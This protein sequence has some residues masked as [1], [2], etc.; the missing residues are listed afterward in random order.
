MWVVMTLTETINNVNEIIAKVVFGHS[1]ESNEVLLR[2]VL[3]KK[4]NVIEMQR[5][6]NLVGRLL[7]K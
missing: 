1:G 7:L 2:E 3:E 4:S 5:R 6:L